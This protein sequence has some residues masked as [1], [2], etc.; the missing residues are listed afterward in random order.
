MGVSSGERYEH[1]GQGRGPCFFPERLGGLQ[2]MQQDRTVTL[3]G[4]RTKNSTIDGSRVR[5]GP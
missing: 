2:K 5:P 4:L 3:L 1:R